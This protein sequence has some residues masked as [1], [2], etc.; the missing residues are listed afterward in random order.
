LSASAARYYAYSAWGF[1][2]LEV[3]SIVVFSGLTLW[4]G[5]AILTGLV[6]VIDGLMPA[7]MPVK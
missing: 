5:F 1:S 2:G 7:K 3:A 6:F 4:L